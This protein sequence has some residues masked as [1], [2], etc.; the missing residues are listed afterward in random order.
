MIMIVDLNLRNGNTSIV[1]FIYFL[2]LMFQMDRKN[3]QC[4]KYLYM[5]SA[6]LS[7]QSNFTLEADSRPQ[8]LNNQF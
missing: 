3:M 5:S 1:C 4:T 2:H 8:A 6:A 7:E